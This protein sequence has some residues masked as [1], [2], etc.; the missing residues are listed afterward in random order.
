MS[1]FNV[2]SSQLWSIKNNKIVFIFSSNFQSIFIS[3][4]VY[5]YKYYVQWPLLVT[6]KTLHLK[7]IVISLTEVNNAVA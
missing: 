2:Q 4:N 5:S 6:R 7:L 3:K 1:Y